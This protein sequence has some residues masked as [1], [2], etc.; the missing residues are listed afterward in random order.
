MKQVLAIASVIAL[1]VAIACGRAGGLAPAASIA[2]SLPTWIAAGDSFSIARAA[3]AECPRAPVRSACYEK[4]MVSIADSGKVGLAMGSLNRLG[5]LDEDVRR[6]G[7][8]YAHAIG[9]AAGKSGGDVAS[10]FTPCTETYQSGCYHGVIQARLSSMAS[11]GS[12]V[13]NA[14]CEPFRSNPSDRWIRFQCVHGM[15]HGLTT[16][17]EHDLPRA[18]ES[19]DLLRDPW[20]RHSCYGGAFMENVVNVTQP[21]HPTKA[22]TRTEKTSREHHEHSGIARYKAIDSTDALYPCSAMASRYLESCYEMQT[23]V[24]LYLNKGDIGAAAKTCDTAPLAMR[25]VCYRSLGRDISS[26][27]AQNHAEGI[28]MCSLGT[29][30]YQRWC[31]IGLVKN[32]I[33]LNARPEDGIALC[34]KIPGAPE[35]ATCYMAVGEQVTVLK[36]SEDDRRASCRTAEEE[37]RPACLYGAG[38]IRE[39]PAIL[40]ERL[41]SR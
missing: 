32:L 3:H 41:D 34:R 5:D 2:T 33:D 24:I 35:K 39:A 6:D 25:P 22:L 26:Y 1:L 40:V 28:R 13:A 23:S 29:A 14:L 17:Y 16:M 4:L 19:C 7:H 8:V 9:I 18:L 10:A 12:K 21:H 37:H 27:S 36:T 15:G 31:F 20:D 38:V 11:V 30:R